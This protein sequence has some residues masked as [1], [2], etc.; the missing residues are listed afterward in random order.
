MDRKHFAV[1]GSTFGT[2]FRVE[3]KMLKEG[4]ELFQL[5]ADTVGNYAR[6]FSGYLRIRGS[7]I[8]VA[9]KLQRDRALTGESHDIVAAK[10]NREQDTHLRLQRSLDEELGSEIPF[11]RMYS[12]S[13]E[14]RR[15]EELLPSILCCHAPHALALHCPEPACQGAELQVVRREDQENEEEKED[16]NDPG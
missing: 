10:F 2:E 14:D 16:N 7:A 3:L 1:N 11:P 6:V 5:H 4:P 9:V 8:L 15:A 13:G 12:L